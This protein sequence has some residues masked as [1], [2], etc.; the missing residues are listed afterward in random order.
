MSTPGRY[1]IR[2]RDQMKGGSTRSRRVG[3][4]GGG[5]DFPCGARRFQIR[6][7]HAGSFTIRS[8]P[9][10][11]GVPSGASGQHPGSR[12]GVLWIPAI[13]EVPR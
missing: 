6:L 4:G 11:S 2:G 10:S 9:S 1:P 13:A 12:F 8:L 7:S 3:G 5:L